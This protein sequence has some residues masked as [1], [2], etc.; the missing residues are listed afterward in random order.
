[1]KSKSQARIKDQLCTRLALPQPEPHRWPAPSSSAS[2]PSCCSTAFPFCCWCHAAMALHSRR[3]PPCRQSAW[4][5]AVLQ[6]QASRQA[7]QGAGWRQE[8]QLYGR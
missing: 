8:V 1:M 3:W 5:Q 4:E 6:Y 7:L 2:C